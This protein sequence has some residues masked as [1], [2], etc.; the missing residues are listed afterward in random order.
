MKIVKIEQ[1]RLR[2]RCQ[3]VKVTT[4]TDLVGWGETTLEGKLGS[5]WAAVEELTDYLMGKD[6]LRI[7]HHWQSMYRSA[8][9]RGGAQNM[10]AISGLEQAMYDIAGKHFGVPSYWL[11]GGPTRDRIKVYAHCG[12]TDFERMDYLVNE[13]GYKAIKSGPGGKWHALETP[14]RNQSFVEEVYGARKHLGPDVDIALDFHGKM[15]PAQ[16]I[17]VCKEI[18]D[19]NPLFVEEPIPQENV[20]ALALIARGTSIPI[21][22]GE[23][24]LTRWG[25]REVVEKQAVAILQPDLARSGGLLETKKI[26]AQAETY[27]IHLAPHSAIGPVAL[28]ACMQVDACIPNFLIQEQ[29]DVALGWGILKEDWQVEDGYIPLPQKPGLGFEIDETA[30]EETYEGEYALPRHF[31]DDDGSVTDW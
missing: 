11:L 9:N 12:L 4:D 10:A 30:L 3:L 19:A 23:R 28:A 5:A 25:F 13:K 22:T 18:E 31:H 2:H 27:Y 21:A 29:V 16:A 6:P 17:R 8:F 7:E 15:T 24:L 1:Y 20:D 14:G 26:A